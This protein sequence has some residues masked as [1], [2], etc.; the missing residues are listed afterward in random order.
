[1]QR[2][3]SFRCQQFKSMIKESWKKIPFQTHTYSVLALVVNVV[4]GK[5]VTPDIKKAEIKATIT[6]RSRGKIVSNGCTS[7]FLEERLNVGLNFINL[8][9][10]LDHKEKDYRFGFGSVI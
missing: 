3:S 7:A 8:S 4:N 1:M 9:A 10:E 6:A 5:S 2:I